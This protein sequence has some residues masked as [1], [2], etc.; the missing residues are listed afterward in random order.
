M[1]GVG[2]GGYQVKEEWKGMM[3]FTGGV[4]LQMRKMSKRRG[5][6]VGS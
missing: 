6:L 2:E 4:L 1:Q 3:D 5:S